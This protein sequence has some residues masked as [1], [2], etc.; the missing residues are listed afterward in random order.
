MASDVGSHRLA[1]CIVSSSG[2]RGQVVEPNSRHI[3]TVEG[4]NGSDPPDVLRPE[5]D[6]QV[7]GLSEKSLGGSRGSVRVVR[8]HQ[9]GTRKYV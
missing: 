9:S 8:S 2:L 5:P 6:G 4:E 3:Q 1:G 7:V